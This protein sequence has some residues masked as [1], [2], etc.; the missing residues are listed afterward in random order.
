VSGCGAIL[1]VIHGQDAIPIQWVLFLLNRRPVTA[2]P[3]V[4][5]PPPERFWRWMP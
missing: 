4:R 1:G 3:R 5:H 2:A